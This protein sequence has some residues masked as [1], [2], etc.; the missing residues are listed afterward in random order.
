MES[1]RSAA[2]GRNETKLKAA[3]DCGSDDDDDDDDDRIEKIDPP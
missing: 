3:I 1:V 2:K